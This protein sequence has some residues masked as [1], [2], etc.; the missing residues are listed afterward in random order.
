MTDTRW[1][2]SPA[3]PHTR[4]GATGHGRLTC[5]PVGAVPAANAVRCGSLEN[6]GDSF[7]PADPKGSVSETVLSAVL[8]GVRECA[9]KRQTLQFEGTRKPSPST[10]FP[11]NKLVSV[12][13]FSIN[14]MCTNISISL[15]LGNLRAGIFTTNTHIDGAFSLL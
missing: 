9:G 10:R 11:G 15:S 4:Q 8:I 1:K 14:T 2:A 6:D 7:Q 3:A 13:S 12:F 5:C